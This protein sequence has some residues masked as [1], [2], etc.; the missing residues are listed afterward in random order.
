MEEV[1]LNVSSKGEKIKTDIKI[2]DEDGY[3]HDDLFLAGNHVELLVDRIAVEF[4]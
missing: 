3:F 2:V 1:G 4:L